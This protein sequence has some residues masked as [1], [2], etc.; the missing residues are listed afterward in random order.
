MKRADIFLGMTVLLVCAVWL[1]VRFF[2]DK[3]GACVEV[4][5]NGTLYGVYDL[6]EDQE[7]DIGS[8]NHI[9]IRD[10]KVRMTYADCPDQV[11]IRQGAVQARGRRIICLPNRVIVSVLGKGARE[12]AEPDVTVP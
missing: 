9:S 5:M 3:N 4:E 11:C 8:G 2:L 6:K 1:G 7:I 12:D 10:G